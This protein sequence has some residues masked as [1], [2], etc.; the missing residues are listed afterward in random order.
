MEVL[1]LLCLTT[2]KTPIPI[3]AVLHLRQ[4]QRAYT[5]A[6][7]QPLRSKKRKS[8]TKVFHDRFYFLFIILENCFTNFSKLLLQAKDF[9]DSRV[10]R[11]IGGCGGD[12]CVSFLHLFRNENAGPDGGDGG[13]GGHVIFKVK[14]SRFAHLIY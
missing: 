8:Q 9:I 5:A 11:T 6:S 12:G 10:V 7:A 13:N 2:K 1:R 14:V 4:F 3:V